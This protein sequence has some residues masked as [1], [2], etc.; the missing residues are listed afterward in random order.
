MTA[1]E[2]LE[3][4]AT[5]LNEL[6]AGTPP[7]RLHARLGVLE[8]RTRLAGL[9]RL[10]DDLDAARRRVHQAGELERRLEAVLAAYHPTTAP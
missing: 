4:A 2:V 7:S 10:A 8:A 1:G 9:T 5:M 3:R 6:R